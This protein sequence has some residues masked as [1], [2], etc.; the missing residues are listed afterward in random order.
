MNT[1]NG[2]TNTNQFNALA[3]KQFDFTTM[4]NIDM[5]AKDAVQTVTQKD[6]QTTNKPSAKAQ[7]TAEISA[8]AKQIAAGIANG[9][10]RDFKPGVHVDQDGLIETSYTH[11]TGKPHD[12]LANL[13]KKFQ[14]EVA[15]HEITPK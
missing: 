4:G 14:T 1:V 15:D 3:N 5:A 10:I 11:A 6:K 9:T 7:D 13:L 2:Y 12:D 8:I